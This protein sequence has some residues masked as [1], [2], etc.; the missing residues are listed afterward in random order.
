[1][2]KIFKITFSSHYFF[3]SFINLFIDQI[4]IEYWLWSDTFPGTRTKMM[5]N[6]IDKLCFYGLKTQSLY[7]VFQ[8]WEE[9]INVK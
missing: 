1:M 9:V 3:I 6:N 7:A 2:T 8:K 4:F 5:H